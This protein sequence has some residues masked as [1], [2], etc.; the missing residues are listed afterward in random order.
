MDLAFF[1]GAMT[2][3]RD[4]HTSCS[5]SAVSVASWFCSLFCL[6]GVFFCFGSLA[7]FFFF[8][9]V[10]SSEEVQESDE[11]DDDSSEISRGFAG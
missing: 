2:L 3:S 5:F 1:L 6:E 7:C 8:V 10:S 4:F 11:D 9:F